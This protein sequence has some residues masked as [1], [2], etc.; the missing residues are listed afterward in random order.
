MEAFDD[1]KLINLAR[2]NWYAHKT[3]DRPDGIEELF[4]KEKLTNSERNTLLHFLEESKY[5]KP[6]SM[7][8][9]KREIFEIIGYTS[10][11][12]W[13][14]VMT[15]ADVEAIFNYLKAGQK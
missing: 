9:M 13:N 12:S 15:K 8:D 14:N 7:G 2:Y 5:Q 6:L 4:S 3:A 11:S 10:N 1:R